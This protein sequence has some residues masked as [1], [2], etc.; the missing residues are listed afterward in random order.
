[1][2]TTGGVP[3]LEAAKSGGDLV[4]QGVVETL[5]QE[6][7]T[8]EQFP[9]M[10]IEGNALKHFE[11]V[12]LPTPEFRQVNETYS[13]SFGTDTEHFWGVTILGG[14][15]YIDNYLLKVTA[16]KRSEKAKQ[17]AKFAKA[18][19]RTWDKQVFHGTGSAKDFKGFNALISEGF[20]QVAYTDGAGS[21]QADLTLA[22]LDETNDLLRGQHGADVIY[23]NRDNR[24]NITNLARNTGGFFPIIDLTTDSF[25][26]QVTQWN[27]IPLRIIGDDRAGAP[28][29]GWNETVGSDTTTSSL[30]FVSFGDDDGVTG[31]L[32]FGGSWEARDFGETEAAPGHLGR[33][34]LYPGI[35]VFNKYSLVRLAGIKQPS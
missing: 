29:L 17:W 19:A 35:A 25:G 9:F 15:V 5:I 21:A 27:D 13:R 2:P 10:T 1:M 32:G 34:E 23:L 12:D 6:S 20:G 22:H 14:E 33:V 7:P 30:Y 24:R 4:K 26:R 3:L 31:L 18:M 28:I 11:E 8:L 16:N